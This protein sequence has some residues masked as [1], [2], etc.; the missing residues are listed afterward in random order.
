MKKG[1]KRPN[2]GRKPKLETEIVN[3]LR[4]KITDEDFDLALETFR[5]AM[6]NRKKNLKAAISAAQFVAEQKIGK[7]PQTLEHT[8]PEGFDITI[9]SVK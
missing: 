4:E 9:R 6:G 2:S 7:A 5:Y 8:A 3:R 1:G